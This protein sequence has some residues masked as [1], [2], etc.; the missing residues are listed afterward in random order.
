MHINKQCVYNHVASVKKKLSQ[1]VAISSQLCM[2]SEQIKALFHKSFSLH[3]PLTIVST[4]LPGQTSFCVILLLAINALPFR[5]EA[6]DAETDIIFQLHTRDEPLF[7]VLSPNNDPPISATQFNPNRPTRIFIHGFRSKQKVLNRYAAA[8]VKAGDFNFIGV[9]WTKGANVYNYYGAKGRVK[10]VSNI[11]HRKF[12]FSWSCN[13]NNANKCACASFFR[14]CLF[15]SRVSR[16]HAN[17][18]I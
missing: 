8:Y 15:R 17:Y 16:L 5:C 2:N 18:P 6:F 9:D 14:V 13:P 4:M 7:T 10:H 3:T 12:R 11:F 1:K